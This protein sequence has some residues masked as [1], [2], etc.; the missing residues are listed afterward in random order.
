MNTFHKKFIFSACLF[1]AS[2]SA[3][4]SQSADSAVLTSSSFSDIDLVK[5]ATPFG[6]S[7]TIGED[8]QT[9]TGV[10]FIKPFKINR[11]ETSYNLWYKVRSWAEKNGYSFKNKGQQGSA[12]ASGK[13]PS[14]IKNYEPVTNIS[15]HDAIV[16]CNALSEMSGLTPCYTYNGQVLRSSFDTASCDLASCNFDTDGYRLPTEAEW[17]YAAR[18]TISGM[19]KGNLSSGQINAKG[20]SDE[21][22][23]EAEVA[24]GFENSEGTHVIGTAGTPFIPSAP[25]EP[26][27][28]NPNGAGLFDMSGNVLEFC[29][30]WIA[31]YDQMPESYAQKLYEGPSYGS[32]R[33][34]RGGSWYMYTLSLASGERYSYDPNEAYNYFGFRI[35]SSF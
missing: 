12:G 7:F 19:Q 34:M 33:V 28:G 23:P 11:Y 16:W 31:P 15:W 30:D 6:D 13:A 32:E 1:V 24:W 18:K 3:I 9:E 8:T 14:Q 27:S 20:I 5:L 26:G 25:P 17:E 35:V 2:G 22:I 10:R 29:W 4:F 21:T